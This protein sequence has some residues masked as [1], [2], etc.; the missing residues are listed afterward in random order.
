MESKGTIENIYQLH[1]RKTMDINLENKNCNE[2]K[3]LILKRFK[4]DNN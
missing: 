2:L 4:E 1:D 3:P